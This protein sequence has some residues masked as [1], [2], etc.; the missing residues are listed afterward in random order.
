MQK[1]YKDGMKQPSKLLLSILLI[2][3]TGCNLPAPVAGNPTLIPG[4]TAILT[5]PPPVL[6]T[7][8]PEPTPTPVPAVRIVN[9]DRALFYG[10]Y[11]LAR[12]EYQTA[13]ETSGETEVRAAALLG[14]ARVDYAEANYASALALLRTLTTDYP[15]TIS[16]PSGFFLLGESYFALGRYQEAAETYTSYMTLRPGLIDSYVYEKIGDGMLEIGSYTDA[17]AAYNA[18]IQAPHLGDNLG[19][20]VKIAQTYAAANDLNAALAL[21]D[22][23]FAQTSNDFLKAQMDLLAGRAHLQR[24]ESELAY[25]RFSHAV[26]N[27]PRAFDSYSALVALVDA[28]VPVSEFDR[29]VVDYYAGQYN[30]ALAALNRYIENNPEHDGSA[31]HFRALTLRALGE[32]QA[33]V[34]SWTVLGSRYLSNRYWVEAWREKAFTQWAYMSQLDAAAQTLLDFANRFSAHAEAPRILFEAARIQERNQQFADRKSV[35]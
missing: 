32:Y 14:L 30:L 7:F 29:G 17:V 11:S 2:F 28:G 31:Y 26:E 3:I 27:Y 12:S 18:A 23:I 25:Q 21:Y 8:T 19:F 24:G 6:P 4:T 13:F 5:Q 34:D 10:D 35:V 9:A 16:L 20:Q 15:G 33:A 22:Q 1:G